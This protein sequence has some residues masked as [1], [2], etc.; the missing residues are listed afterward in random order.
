M[1][2]SV[3]GSVHAEYGQVPEE[4]PKEAGEWLLA[5]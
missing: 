5:T 3:Y 1:C 4:M 2:V